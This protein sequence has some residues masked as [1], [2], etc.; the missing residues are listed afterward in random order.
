MQRRGVDDEHAQASSCEDSQKIVV[1]SYDT[2]AEREREPGLDSVHLVQRDE[3][4]NANLT[5][6]RSYV[7]A[8]LDEYG[9]IN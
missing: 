2:F 4:T 5:G 1:V 7:E 3:M 8:L 9:K 6:L